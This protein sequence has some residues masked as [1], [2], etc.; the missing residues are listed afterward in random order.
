[1]R[2]LIWA[3]YDRYLSSLVSNETAPPEELCWSDERTW[4]YF[5]R[6][7]PLSKGIRPN[8]GSNFCSSSERASADG[9][10]EGA[11]SCGGRQGVY[12]AGFGSLASRFGSDPSA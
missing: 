7:S 2:R 5:S 1:M 10:A 12:S 3:K 8:R 4:A 9:R 6:S 11:Y